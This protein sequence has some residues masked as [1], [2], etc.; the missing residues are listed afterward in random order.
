MKT[1]FSYARV[2][3]K[4]QEEKKNSI[5]EQFSRIDNFSINNNITVIKQF[6]DSDSAYH[7]TKRDDFSEM[8]NLAILE[9]PDYII[10]DD[11]SRFARTREI[12]INSKKILRSHGITILYAS[13]PNVNPNTVSGFWL[14]G[15][16][17][18][19]NEATSREIAFHT[20]KGMNR[21][22]QN[23]DEKTG[24]CYKNGGIPPYG[25]KT[26]QLYR[27]KDLRGKPIYKSIW[28]LHEEHA[29][30]MRMIIVDLYTNQ[31]M[32][33]KRIR[34]YLNSHN[35][36]N[37]NGNLWSTTTIASM[38]REDLLEEYSGTAFWNKEN[39]NVEGIK[40]NDRSEWAICENAH[41]SIITTEEL[42]N[43]L[44]RKYKS[45]R[46]CNYTKG[47]SD[48]L[49][50]GM[51]LENEFM[52]I[53]KCCGGHVIGASNGKKSRRNYVCSNNRTKGMCA[54]ENNSKID[55]DWLEA[56]ILREIQR[57]YMTPK[58][59]EKII[60]NI[61]ESIKQ[62]ASSND[63]KIKELNISIK[64]Y[65]KEIKL[66]LDSIKS[67][68]NPSLIADEV[69]KLVSK[70]EQLEQQ[71]KYTKEKDTKV[72]IS[73]KQIL[74]YFSN[75]P[76][77]FEIATID[78]KKKLLKTFIQKIRFDNKNRQIFLELYPDFS[79]VHTYGAGNGNRTRNLTLARLRFTT[80]LYLQI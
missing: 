1:A 49:F 16:Q 55:K 13:E 73:E 77:L 26:V 79:V 57:K 42:N 27:G 31:N 52:F 17:E 47:S 51:N 67:G 39:K 30:I 41:P 35:I 59:I 50:S 24:W 58:G 18:I 20:K 71:L 76:K 75:L 25:Y 43:A 38:L 60:V 74:E 11:S 44:D 69:N 48:Y 12:A 10:L 68:I 4:E 2:S 65:D 37:R 78:E 14:E 33:Y 46:N 56:T 28:E 61:S 66:L 3:T 36:K 9:R 32:S 19:K 64:K 45:R 62:I 54:C 15:I 40:Y 70:K 6:Y 63:Q 53:C 34:D 80:K 7:D 22:I 5:P 72:T 21:N 8:I 29:P 23:R